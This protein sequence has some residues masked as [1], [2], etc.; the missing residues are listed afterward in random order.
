[1]DMVRQALAAGV[2][3]PIEIVVFVKK[4]S[5]MDM[6]TSQVSNYKSVLKKEAKPANGRRRRG[7]GRPKQVAVG[8]NGRTQGYADKVSQLKQLVQQ[9]GAEEVKKLAEILA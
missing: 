2:E 3:K 1:M 6:T 5:G 8:S 7:P 9:L 4:Q